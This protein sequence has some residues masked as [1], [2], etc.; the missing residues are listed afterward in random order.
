MRI[1][2]YGRN[3]MLGFT[4]IE[5]MVALFL[6][7]IVT[8]AAMAVY[9]TQHK[10]M[11]VQDEISDMQASIRASGEEL[12]NKIKM[13]GFNVPN[14][15]PAIE[16]WNTNPDTIAVTYDL[17]RLRDVT[18]EH[19]MP[20]P[21]AELRCDGHDISGLED[22]DWVYIFDPILESGEWLLCT[23]AQYS[24]QH[25]QHR[26]HTLSHRYPAGSNILMLNRFKYYIDTTDP[27]HPNLI[28]WTPRH[29]AQVFAENITDLNIQYVLTNGVIVDVPPQP[30]MIREVIINIDARTDKA[31]EDFEVEYRT[32]SLQ[33]RVK[34]RNLGIG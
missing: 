17:G 15:M 16:A 20:N 2:K 33:T 23:Q 32:R 6:A 18:I 30:E 27:D 28:Q 11:L 5:M 10:Q 24:S 31:D 8:S 13:A 7:T 3:N 19:A 25:I 14:I 21:S 26:D 34:V 12:S 9:I 22:G 29:G 4:L 1:F